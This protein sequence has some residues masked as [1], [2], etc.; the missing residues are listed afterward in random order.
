MRLDLCTFVTELMTLLKSKGCDATAHPRKHLGVGPS[1]NPHLNTHTHPQ[2]QP[3]PTPNWQLH[4]QPRTY[5]E[6]LTVAASQH[7]MLRVCCVCA[8]AEADL[9]PP[10]H[11]P[12]RPFCAWGCL[13][14]PGALGAL[15][16]RTSNPTPRWTHQQHDTVV[17]S[18]GPCSSAL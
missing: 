5:V 4:G 16:V 10:I 3:Q 13:D 14:V 15:M 7:R 11:R 6:P 8:C 2:P 18:D 12:T 9:H 1:P 17:Y